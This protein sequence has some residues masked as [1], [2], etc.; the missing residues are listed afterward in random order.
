MA[1]DREKFAE[2]VTDRILSHPNIEV[3][4]RE[5]TDL[6]FAENTVVATGPLT[7]ARWLRA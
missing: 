7:S 1:V 3:V 2:A 4:R 6:D 5:V